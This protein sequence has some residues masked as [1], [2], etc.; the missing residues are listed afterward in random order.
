MGRLRAK[1]K[2]A[3]EEYIRWRA[4]GTPGM[5]YHAVARKHDI[6]PVLLRRFNKGEYQEGL[7]CTD[8]DDD[9]SDEESSMG[10]F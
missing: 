6:A 10:D 2:N 8:A 5:G 3:R 1:Y 7:D 9:S 4:L